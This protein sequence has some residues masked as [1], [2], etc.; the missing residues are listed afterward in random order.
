MMTTQSLSKF[1]NAVY[2]VGLWARKQHLRILKQGT[3][4]FSSGGGRVL[5][6]R[7][8]G[9]YWHSGGEAENIDIQWQIGDQFPRFMSELPGKKIKVYIKMSLILG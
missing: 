6:F 7:G 9:E 3:T 1:S 4:L 5:A 2:F 8:G